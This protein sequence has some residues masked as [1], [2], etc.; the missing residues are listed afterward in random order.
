M[1]WWKSYHQPEGVGSFYH[2]RRFPWLITSFFLYPGVPWESFGL[3]EIQLFFCASGIPAGGK[4]VRCFQ[5]SDCI[6]S[7]SHFLTFKTSGHHQHGCCLSFL[8]WKSDFC[9]VKQNPAKR[10]QVKRWCN[11]P[12]N[13][14][15][16]NIHHLDL[17][18]KV[19]Q[20]NLSTR[21]PPPRS[22][23]RSPLPS[24]FRRSPKPRR[25]SSLSRPA[26]FRHHFSWILG[27]TCGFPYIFWGRTHDRRS[28]REQ[29][30]SLTHGDLITWKIFNPAGLHYLAN[31]HP[32]RPA[33][34]T[35]L[36]HHSQGKKIGDFLACT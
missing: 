14:I 3:T 28:C 13:K 29:W 20:S 7:S 24:K 11:L 18:R 19:F 25:S 23:P 33:P 35:S 6:P 26:I 10:V 31:H 34:M 5:F 21:P 9:G 8:L 36:R 32:F 2:F 12:K 17:C 16:K 30:N 22:P 15:K 4:F 1:K 27:K